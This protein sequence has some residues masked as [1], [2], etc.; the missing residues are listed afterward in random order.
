MATMTTKALTFNQQE[1]WWSKSRSVSKRY[2]LMCDALVPEDADEAA[3]F[4]VSERLHS[5]VEAGDIAVVEELLAAGAD[6]NSI[7]LHGRT[8]LHLAAEAGDIAVVEELLAAGADVN[9]IDLHGRT[10]LHLVAEAGD[11][12]VVEELL[13]AGA[14]V[15]ARDNGDEIPYAFHAFLDTRVRRSLAIIQP[16]SSREG[17]VS[18]EAMGIRSDGGATPLHW[19]AAYDNA[20]AVVALLAGGSDGAAT[21]RL[22]SVPPFTPDRQI[23]PLSAA[24]ALHWAAEVDAVDAVRAFLLGGMDVDTRDSNGATVLHR[25]AHRGASRTVT[26]LLAAGANVA[27]TSYRG[28]TALHI[29]ARAHEPEI[30]EQ[31]LAAGATV[32][33]RVGGGDTPLHWSLSAQENRM[34]SRGTSDQLR[35]VSLNAIRTLQTLFEHGADAGLMNNA[36]E[37]PLE[38][39]MRMGNIALAEI[40]ASA[41]AYWQSA[42]VRSTAAA[43]RTIEREVGEVFREC[44]MC[45]LMTVV[46][47]GTFLKGSPPSAVWAGEDDEQQE[48][49]IAAPF[50]VGVYEVTF[51]EWDACVADEG[52]HGYIPDDNGWGRDN[53]PVINVGWDDALAYLRW[54]SRKT[55]GDYRLLTENEWEYVARAGTT[56]ARYWG[57]DDPFYYDNEQCTYANGADLAYMEQTSRELRQTHMFVT[58]ND[59]AAATAHVGSY[60]PNVFGLHDVLGNVWELTSDCGRLSGGGAWYAEAQ[61]GED[62][63]RRVIR[64][65]S[66]YAYPGSLRAARRAEILAG[67]RNFF[68][69]GFRVARELH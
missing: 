39:A 67:E 34:Y 62:C 59:G 31:L 37:T 57:D 45:P 47:T 54:L 13:A 25:A 58:C 5:A 38:L 53:K 44:A 63:R 22:F 32:N 14:N 66:W 26:A 21:S 55:G 27:L 1:P 49:T 10:P 2:C 23:R 40:A 29:A 16:F 52:C 9:S 4:E 65:G 8:P 42:G 12:A 69:R 61:T 48:K 68:D 56:T 19:A 18:L 28:E 24:T 7:A 20:S 46:P 15:H 64:G 43:D 51:A 6:V 30:V 50:A 35:A 36:G 3:Q 17:W 33:A 11:I 41:G 60:Q